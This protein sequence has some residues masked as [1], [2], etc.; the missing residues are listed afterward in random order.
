MAERKVVL[1][2]AIDAAHHLLDPVPPWDDV[3]STARD[4]VGADSG[5]LI[6]FD[7][8]RRLLNLTAVGF[9]ESCSRDYNGY[10]Y[11]HDVLERDSRSA[12]AG[13]WLDTGQM[14]SNR[15][16]QRTEFHA[17]FMRK[18]RMAQIFV[19]VV[20]SSP[21]LRAA[22]GFQRSSVDP[23]AVARL[24][25][26]DADRYFRKLRELLALRHQ[27]LLGGLLAVETA[28]SALDE[29]ICL[30][31][32]DATVV[33]TSAHTQPFFSDD[34]G[35]L[36]RR[37]VLSHR[38]PAINA[39]FASA[40]RGCSEDGRSRRVVIPAGWGR[41]TIADI[42]VA[43]K[44]FGLVPNAVFFVRLRRRSAFASPDA[45]ELQA[46]F[47]ITPAEARVLAGLAAGH[48]VTEIAALRR[49]SEQTV[50][51][52]V[53]SLMRKMECHRQSELV[54]LALMV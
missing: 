46:V 42:G 16:L 27:Q 26:G 18:H 33:R 54:K 13:T 24:T 23:N 51:K 10:F 3:L 36:I 28:F 32:V 41:T 39:R 4:L 43:T 29:A 9:T 1:S 11:S 52:Q 34:V 45:D 21:L 35:F 47:S 14:Y 48:S 37:G 19:L 31:M 15:Q 25:N 5:T 7:N 22:I 17:D 53:S 49:S 20:E 6:V 44:F 38:D 50:R 12:P 40:L 2:R 8:Q 30:V